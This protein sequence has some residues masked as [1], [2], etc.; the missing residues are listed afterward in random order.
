MIAQDQPTN[1]V[2]PKRQYKKREPKPTP[3]PSLQAT[4]SEP[5]PQATPSEPNPRPAKRAPKPRAP[6]VKEES[7]DEQEIEKL[8]II[9]S[10]NKEL[11][12]EINDIITKHGN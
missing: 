5:T 6:R 11:C 7:D 1:E 4:P 3:Q 10:Q 2:K 12:K 9:L 8:K